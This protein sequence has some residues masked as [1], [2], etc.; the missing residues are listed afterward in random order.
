M[1]STGLDGPYR[2][3]S[4]RIDEV[5]KKTSAGTYVLERKD[6]SDSFIVNYVGR[7]DDDVN[8]RLK[9]WVGIRGY[10]RFK[11]GYFGSPKAAN[12]PIYCLDKPDH[13]TPKVYHK[14]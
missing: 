7:S 12:S 4:E 2:L 5:V 14:S 3:S 9:K 1:T 11:F 8:G 13:L 6:S 10:K